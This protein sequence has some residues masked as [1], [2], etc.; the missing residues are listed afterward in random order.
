M[1]NANLVIVHMD[2][3]SVTHFIHKTC[4]S[5]H[6][7]ITHVLCHSPVAGGMEQ[8]TSLC[9]AAGRR[10]YHICGWPPLLGLAC[11]YLTQNDYSHRVRI[12]LDIRRIAD[13]VRFTAGQSSEGKVGGRIEAS[14]K[15]DKFLAAKAHFSTSQWGLRGSSFY[16]ILSE[17]SAS[18]RIWV[19]SPGEVNQ[20]KN[21]CVASLTV[22][23]PQKHFM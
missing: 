10:N 17:M 8:I 3:F 6:V 9:E 19:E 20:K 22:W 13:E 18:A 11:N 23:T 12:S 4:L 2:H 1:I 14:V 16:K 15:E 21:Y 7:W 5:L